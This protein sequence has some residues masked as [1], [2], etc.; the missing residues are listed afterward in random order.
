MSSALSI[1]KVGEI[2]LL[3]T[4]EIAAQLENLLSAHQDAA[5]Q[6]RNSQMSQRSGLSTIIGTDPNGLII[7]FEPPSE[8]RW[9]TIWFIQNLMIQQRMYLMDELARKEGLIV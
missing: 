7:F 4:P 1:H 3:A 8:M 6:K 9:E 2:G 5:A